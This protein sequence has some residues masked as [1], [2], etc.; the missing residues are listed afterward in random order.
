MEKLLFLLPLLQPPSAISSCCDVP[1][2]VAG[3]R[4]AVGGLQ[5]E[6]PFDS[7]ET[8]CRQMRSDCI[9]NVFIV[10]L[11]DI[12]GANI[13]GPLELTSLGIYY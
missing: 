10:N 12:F 3:K 5:N 2:T 1:R 8:L 11:F 9:L 4:P 7:G 13:S 6:L